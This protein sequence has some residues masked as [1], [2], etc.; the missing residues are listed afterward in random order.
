MPEWRGRKPTNARPALENR[1]RESNSD[2]TNCGA[3]C[4]FSPSFRLTFLQ[5]P[6]T[7]PRTATAPYPDWQHSGVLAILTTPD[8]ADLPASAREKG[9][10]ILVRLRREW[11][12][13]S[14]A[15]PD[16]ADISILGPGKASGLRNRTVG[17]GPGTACIWVRIPVIEGN[18]AERSR[19]TGEK[20][21]LRV[22]PTER[23]SST[24][25][26]AS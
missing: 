13:F 6:T 8:G 26:M 11:F 25:P 12:D 10:P 21:T 5:P 22:S 19:C 1:C 24:R 3:C 18:A 23:Q 2:E 15:L 16:G 20:L 4:S 17:P 9:F 14:Q 7:V